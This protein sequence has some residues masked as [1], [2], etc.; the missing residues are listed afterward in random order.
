MLAVEPPQSDY[1]R[2]SPI[3]SVFLCIFLGGNSP[4]NIEML[5]VNVNQDYHLNV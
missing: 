1:A 4:R 5:Q 3:N 2:V